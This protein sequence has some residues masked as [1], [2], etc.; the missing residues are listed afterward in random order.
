MKTTGDLTVR[1]SPAKIQRVPQQGAGPRSLFRRNSY[2]PHSSPTDVIDAINPTCQNP[3]FNCEVAMT[4]RTCT[5]W[6]LAMLAANLATT[7]SA[8]EAAPP[9][10]VVVPPTEFV[11]AADTSRWYAG[12]DVLWLARDYSQN[13]LL[14]QTVTAPPP[15]F[16]AVPLGGAPILTLGNVTDDMAQPGLRVRF[17]FRLTDATSI[18]LGYFG[19]QEWTASA[20]IPAGDPPF[21]N[22][23]FLGSSIIY[24]NRSFDTGISAQYCSQIHSAEANL[25]RSFSVGNWNAAALGGFRYFYLSE[26]LTLTG[27][28]TF[29]NFKPVAPPAS[30]TF[31][32]QTRTVANNNLFGAQI[33]GE[34]GRTWFDNRF[35]LA[36]NGKVGIFANNANQLTS[37][38]ARLITGGGTATSTLAAGRGNTDFASLYE[39]GITATVRVTSRIRV[40]GGY[41]ALFVQ[42]LALAPTQLAATG[43]AIQKS[44]Q[45]VPGSFIPFAPPPSTLPPPGTGSGLNTNGNLLLHG[46]FVGLDVSY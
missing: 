28:Q 43:T 20:S 40:R 14:A 15:D 41:Q 10:P 4:S 8:Q 44:S 21:A 31:V 39:G 46:P 12:V 38:G 45:L 36:A 5:R 6:V 29:P 3:S 7:S 1:R 35:G 27:A 22:S 33:G 34:L 13:M 30:Q 23:P 2:I 37:N 18:E 26:Q 25:R 42:G 19:L 32:E 24:G 16:K 9:A 17:G 11:Q